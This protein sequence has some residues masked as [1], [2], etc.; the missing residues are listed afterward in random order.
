LAFEDSFQTR[1]CQILRVCH[2]YES[3]DLCSYGF[4]FVGHCRVQSVQKRTIS[5]GKRKK[6]K[7]PKKKELLALSLT[8]E[9][10][11]LSLRLAL[12]LHNNNNKKD[13]APAPSN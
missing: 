3:I 7:K 5:V 13:S 9:Q 6:R 10:L 12:S 1:A 8:N 4:P 2:L 11:Q